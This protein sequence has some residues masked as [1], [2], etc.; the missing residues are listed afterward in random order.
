MVNVSVYDHNLHFIHD[1]MLLE[2]FLKARGITYTFWLSLCGTYGDGVEDLKEKLFPVV[3]IE[4][5]SDRDNWILFNTSDPIPML[6]T[7]WTDQLFKKTNSWISSTNR[8]P[9]LKSATEL[10]EKIVTHIQSRFLD[11]K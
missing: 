1:V 11:K 8:H 5:I 4:K 7:S 3:P 10:A 9:N 6:G 2:N